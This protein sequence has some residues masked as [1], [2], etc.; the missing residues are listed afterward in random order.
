M[1]LEAFQQ[2]LADL[3]ASPHLCVKVR[4]DASFLDSYALDARERRR[5]L[6]MVRHPGMSHNCT[7]YRANR[8]TPIARS[9]PRTCVRLGPRLAAELESFWLAEPNSELQF[10]RE[11]ERFAQFLLQRLRPGSP[12]DASIVDDIHAELKSLGLRFGADIHL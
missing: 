2:A 11:A 6:A 1:S 9:L 4:H 12:E 3:V 7:L 8:L 10:K 5:L